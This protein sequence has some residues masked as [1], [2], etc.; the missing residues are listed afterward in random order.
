MP[1]TVDIRDS[2]D[3]TFN[4]KKDK[5]EIPLIEKN[6]PNAL[7][8]LQTTNLLKYDVDTGLGVMKAQ[9]IGLLEGVRWKQYHAALGPTLCEV[10]AESWDIVKEEKAEDMIHVL[11]FPYNG[12][13]PRDRLVQ[14][15]LTRN[16]DHFVRNHGG[17]PTCDERDYFLD[18]C[19]MVKEPKRLTMEDLKNEDLFPPI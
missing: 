16:E 8:F 11:D 5:T 15:T 3:H 1:A 17:I 13:P 10:P 12:E 2:Q 14:T 4:N 19:G 7:R 18:I 9:L 6:H